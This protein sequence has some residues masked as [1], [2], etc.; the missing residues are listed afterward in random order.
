MVGRENEA[1]KLQN[2]PTK[3]AQYQSM[4]NKRNIEALNKGL[5]DYER[6]VQGVVKAQTA[7]DFASKETDYGSLSVKLEAAKKIAEQ[8]RETLAELEK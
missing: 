2:D 3:G 7:L 8:A 6:A 1:Y 5:V 4:A